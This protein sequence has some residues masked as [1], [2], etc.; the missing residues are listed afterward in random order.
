MTPR[1][2]R[3]PSVVLVALVVLALLPAL[4]PAPA[5]AESP[6]ALVGQLIRDRVQQEGQARVI[7]ELA[8]PSGAAAPEG[9]LDDATAGA[10]RLDIASVRAQLLARLAGSAHRVLHQYE[11]VP[12]V[13]LE[14]GPDAV[15]GIEASG[16]WVK[17][18]MPDT[19]NRPTL[20]QSVPLIGGTQAW[21]MGYDGTGTVVAIVDTGVQSS[22]PFLAGKVVEEAC[23]SS[24]V[25][26]QST[27][28]CPNG[29]SQQLGAGAG[30]NCPVSDCWHGTHV[31]GIAA[32]NGAGAG[33]TFSG[34]ARGARIMAVQVFSRFNDAT[35]CG[36]SPPCVL[37]YT[38]DIIAGLERV[39]AMR[40]TWNIA[41]ANMSLGGAASTTFCDS[42]PTKPI[43]DNLRA[44]GIATVIASGN[45]GSRNSVSAP[46]CIS[47]AISVG[48]TT[49]SDVVAS[50][51][52]V[53]W[54]MSVYAPGQNINSSVVPSGFGVASG[55]SM[56][57]PHVTGAWA[58][59]K[60]AAA[61]AS[62][63]QILSALQTTGLPIPDTRLGGAVTRPRIRIANALG[64]LVPA[65]LAVSPASVTAGTPVTATWTNIATP[66]GSDWIGL[67]LP[68]SSDASVNTRIY[69]N[70][71]AS[72]GGSGAAAGSCSFPIAASRPAGT[73]QLRLFANNGFTRLAASGTFTVTAPAPPTLSASP[74]SVAV[75][76]TVTATWANIATPTSTDWIGLYAVGADD[77]SYATWRYVSCSTLPGPTGLASGSCGLPVPSLVPGSYELRLF[78]NN[79]YGRIATSAPFTVTA[80]VVATLSVSPSSVVAG[81]TV[82]AT[83]S[84]ITSP[85][86]ADWI[87]LF[88]PGTADTAFLARIYTNCTAS[89]GAIGVAAGSC[90][91][92]LSAGLTARS[93]ELRLFRN[94][95]FT[96]LAT[97][98]SFT[99]TAGV[100]LSVSPP[101]VAAGGAVT[102]TWS[103][104]VAP[105]GGDWIGLYTPAAADGAYVARIYVNCAASPGATGAAGG[106]CP[107][108]LS[109]GLTPGSYQLRLFSNN[110]LTRLAVSGNFT[111]NAPA[112]L[113]VSPTAMSAGGAV[114]AT[115]A[116]ITGPTGGDWIG[117]FVPGTSDTA[118]LSRIFVNCTTS[119][120]AT[121]MAAGSCAFPLSAGLTP[122]SY[123]L[124][125][126]GNN[127]FTRLA[128]SS[129]FDVAPP[130]TLSATPATVTA[131]TSVTATW[132]GIASPAGGDWIGL[133]VPG[134][135]DASYLA[136]IFVS[137]GATP[138]ATGAAA[139]S[140][141]FPLSAALT[142]RSYELRLF[143]NNTFIRLAASGSFTVVAPTTLTAS[144]ASVAAGTSVTA[145]WSGI[146]A[147]AGGDWI[148][149][150]PPA[151]ADTAF[152]AR[153]FVNCGASPGAVGV[154]AGTCA[155]PIPSSLTP[156][157]YQLRLFRSGGYTRLATS[158]GF[159]VTAAVTQPT[160]TASPTSVAAGGAVTAV[161]SG[162]ATPT[163]T[164]W[165]AV[166]VPGAANN[167]YVA[168]TFTS[169]SQVP[170]D[171]GVAAGSCDVAIPAGL[172]P[173]T[174]ELRL[175]RNNGYTRLATS[176]PFGV[177]P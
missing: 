4:R 99:V 53:A 103:G 50:F 144:P 69:T 9:D 61:G 146:T 153:I 114:T 168:W 81:G 39:Y 100:A 96:K 34:V 83:W 86:G 17:R 155:F 54:F 6:G 121:G 123:E 65:T 98:G 19:L 43:I 154:P 30:V 8:L 113:A 32:G 132:S 107:F 134:A 159:T 80:A 118:Y 38:S 156:A 15:A 82:T 176:N 128:T 151:A 55:T 40:N 84:G 26:G 147:A 158:N 175:F 12:L 74:A 62:V 137:C 135:A 16:F 167:S 136:R 47:T 166:A 71:T 67:Y 110:T 48:A 75:G 57:T 52:N 21:T 115:W 31:A 23:F 90:P 117:L 24:T 93:Y 37:A 7:V 51:S 1:R 104:I 126:F 174:Y 49:K 133:Y 105:T 173:G 10:Q 162:V 45:D 79:G 152:L 130:A 3:G 120:G 88:V 35:N 140:C 148:G 77:A 172:A 169:C 78:A 44:A 41:A 116:S 33:V 64:V 46:G 108:A 143:R 101:V 119:A 111:V 125:L 85:A 94:N 18:V 76:G 92:P 36:G 70:C 163:S 29:Q 141:A 27:S 68:G 139:G 56:A 89:A 138:G 11:T 171:V 102:A 42:D 164:D 95:G 28:V 112:T 109:A 25:S 150:Y 59:L 142:P 60:Q 122:R 5:G 66:T 170:A 58:V 22:H 2:G 161:W 145:A 97:S 63:S 165:I 106:A 91:F 14:I 131:G 129:P 73:Y 127:T 20:A 124:R 72:A 160:L 149:L 87:G 13:A 157:G 177:T